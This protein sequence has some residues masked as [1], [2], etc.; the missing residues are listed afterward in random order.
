[1][2]IWIAAL[3][4]GIF[5]ILIGVQALFVSGYWDSFWGTYITYG[6]GPHWVLGII[7]IIGGLYF[8]Y[9]STRMIIRDKKKGRPPG[10][11]DQ[12]RR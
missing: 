6:P 9:N 5:L 3:I 1:M 10:D 8:I 2:I 12:G 11:G 7:L 4:G